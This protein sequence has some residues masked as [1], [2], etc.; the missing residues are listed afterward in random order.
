M[1]CHRIFFGLNAPP[2]Q[3][4]QLLEPT[5]CFRD[6]NEVRV[7]ILPR[8]S[9][10]YFNHATSQ[11]LEELLRKARDVISTRPL[12]EI[13]RKAKKP[14]VLTILI[15]VLSEIKPCLKHTHTHTH[16]HTH[17]YIYI[18]NYIALAGYKIR[19][20]GTEFDRF[21]LIV[22]LL[23]EQSLYVKEPNLLYYFTFPKKS[24]QDMSGIAEEVT[25]SL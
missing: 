10:C 6:R 9:S 13:F 11:S 1:S 20:F 22:Y 16:T 25:T 12:Y 5:F 19:W 7:S 15:E 18:Y 21:L 4:T 23:Q 2:F 24:E 8:V 14:S 3:E 17:I